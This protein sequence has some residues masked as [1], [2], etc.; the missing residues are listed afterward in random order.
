MFVRDYKREHGYTAPFT[1]LGTCDYVRYSGEKP[2]SFVWE[3][4]EEMPP[5]LVAR[6]YKSM[7]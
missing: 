2:I 5:G 7:V 4:R 6:A 3:L 1:F